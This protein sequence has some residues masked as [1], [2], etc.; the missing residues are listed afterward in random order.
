[1]NLKKDEIDGKMVK[2]G[3][4]IL[5][6]MLPNDSVIYTRKAIWVNRELVN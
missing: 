1:M 2:N 3:E 6:A 4:E 5:A